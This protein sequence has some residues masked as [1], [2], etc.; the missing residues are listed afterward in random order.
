MAGET[1]KEKSLH[2]K[3]HITMKYSLSFFLFFMVLAG[4]GNG[5]GQTENVSEESPRTAVTLTSP[6]WGK[7]DCETVLPAVTAYQSKASV[8]SPVPAF[9]TETLVVPGSRVTAGQ[10]IFIMQSKESRALGDEARIPVKAAMDGIVLEV[11]Q[12]TG[13]YVAEGAVLCTMAESSSLVFEINVPA[14]NMSE[15][16][17]RTGCV[18][19]L[20]DG[21]RLKAKTLSSLV[22]MNVESQSV[23]LV[24]KATALLQP[25]GT[26]LDDGGQVSRRGVPFLPEGLNVKAIFTDNRKE[27]VAMILPRAAVQSDEALTEHWVMK[28]SGDSTAVKVPV[29]V[30]NSSASEVEVSSEELSVDDRVILT[31]GYG[32]EDGAKVVVAE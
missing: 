25:K 16:G 10:D 27:N 11:R 22:Q 13:D 32:L 2:D 5:G 24:A 1:Y 31:G 19:E 9:I 12:Q 21:T 7:I 30:G 26:A 18:I 14:E 17:L 6:I 4:C 29:K 3:K 23:K 20:P 28:M 15:I 8:S